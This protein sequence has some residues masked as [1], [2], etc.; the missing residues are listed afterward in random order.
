[1]QLPLYKEFP[2]RINATHCNI[3]NKPINLCSFTQGFKGQLFLMITIGI[4]S[5]AKVEV[6]EDT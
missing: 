1:M 6:K 4:Y 3:E 2:S 5:D